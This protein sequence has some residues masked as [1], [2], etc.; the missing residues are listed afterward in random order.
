VPDMWAH[1][2]VTNTT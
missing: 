2:S 1:L